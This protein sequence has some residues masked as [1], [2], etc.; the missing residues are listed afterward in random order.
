[1]DHVSVQKETMYN[2]TP[3]NVFHAL[4]VVLFVIVQLLVKIVPYHYYLKMD[5]VWLD[6]TL[7]SLLQAKLVPHAQVDV[8]IVK[9]PTHV[10]YV[11][12]V[13]TCIE[14]LVM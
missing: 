3:W 13:F 12:Q 2:Q 8:L 14:E 5:H 1:M 11:T 7:D 10:K 4:V 9:K 6:A